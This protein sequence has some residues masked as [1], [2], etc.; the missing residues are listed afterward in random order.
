MKKIK[1]IKLSPDLLDRIKRLMWRT[2]EAV[3]SDL[4]ALAREDGRSWSTRDEVIEVVL[5]AD[6]MKGR[7][8]DG[9]FMICNSLPY[10]QAV[11]IARKVFHLVRYE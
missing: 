3:G 10:E 5:D 11:S 2:Y 9:A 6:R 8:D 4:A 7:G 1:E